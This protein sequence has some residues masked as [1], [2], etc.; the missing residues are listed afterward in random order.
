M[1]LLFAL[2]KKDPLEDIIK[3]NIFHSGL[4]SVALEPELTP[5]KL[6]KERWH[7]VVTEP[8][9]FYPAVF[10]PTILLV[11]QIQWWK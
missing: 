6:V 10:C 8:Q 1:D 5:A 9:S 11:F 3:H 4:F 2:N 7:H